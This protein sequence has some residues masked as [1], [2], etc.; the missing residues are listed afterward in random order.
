MIG[1]QT[2]HQLQYLIHTQEGNRMYPDLMGLYLLRFS[3]AKK[4]DSKN[5]PVLLTNEI[6]EM[7]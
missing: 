6:I 7:G 5:I 3:S 4:P 1:L 2:L